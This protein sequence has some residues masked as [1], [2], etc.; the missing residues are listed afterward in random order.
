VAPGDIV[1]NSPWGIGVSATTKHPREAWKLLQF[2]ERADIN[3]KLGTLSGLFPANLKA[4]VDTASMYPQ[5]KTF[6][7]MYQN[8]KSFSHEMAELRVAENL[9]TIYVEEFQAYMLGQINADQ[10]QQNTQNRWME[11]Y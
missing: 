5:T 10:M 3:E 1:H 8:A 9:M 6:Y 4:P 2:I 11:N 7:D